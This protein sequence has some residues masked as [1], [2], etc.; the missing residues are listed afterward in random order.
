MNILEAINAPNVKLTKSDLVLLQYVKTNGLNACSSP[1]SEIAQCCG[2]SH[3][4]VTRF[5]R[6]FGYASL[7]SFKIALA[8]EI[9]SQDT[10]GHLISV[11]FAYD[12]NSETT[13]K[14]LTKLVESTIRQTAQDINHKNLKQITKWLINSKRIYFIGRGNS[15]FAAQDSAYKFHRIG[16]DA[17]AI[18]DTH[19]MIIQGTMVNKKDLIVAIS[20][21]GFSPEIIKTVE[22]AQKEGAKVVA[23]TAEESSLLAKQADEVLLYTVRE[24]C[25]DSGSIY[26]KIA[27]FFIIDLLYTEVCKKLGQS[28]IDSKQKTTEVL[29]ELNFNIKAA[30]ANKT[31]ESQKTE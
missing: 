14:K 28:A 27:V 12:E 19:E 16:L 11:H 13:A 1:I 4:T 31:K 5:A 20:N 7:R 23:I 21:S 8:Q 2:V 30:T 25:L 15:G 6:K 24:S 17:H 29:K 22:L 9:G 26:S 18:T 3:A 10:S